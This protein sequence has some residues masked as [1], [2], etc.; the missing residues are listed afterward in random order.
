MSE[1]DAEGFWKGTSPDGRGRYTDLK[2]VGQGAYSVVVRA[3]DR[4][5]NTTVAI[6]KIAEVFY[7]AHEAKKVLREVRLLRDFHH[8][9]IISLRDLVT[10]TSMESF[11]D[12]WMVT[13]FMEGDL[14]KRIKSKQE[15]P[16][17]T[18]RAYMAQLLSALAHVHGQPA[19]RT[20]APAPPA[21]RRCA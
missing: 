8:P 7:D 11:T 18:V 14:R 2:M 9:H 17:E 3:T 19:R 6:K 16:V 21:R 13:D 5:S 20:R 1:L 15:M 10:V 12:I 4:T